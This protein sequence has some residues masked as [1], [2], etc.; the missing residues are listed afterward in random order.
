[1]DDKYYL[2]NQIHII[3]NGKYVD[4]G[5]RCEDVNGNLINFTHKEIDEL[6]KEFKIVE[7]GWRHLASIILFSITGNKVDRKIPQRY[8]DQ[9]SYMGYNV[10]KLEYELLEDK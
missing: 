1:M 8:I 4:F 7:R 6:D 5:I 2:E 9:L 3:I 10:D